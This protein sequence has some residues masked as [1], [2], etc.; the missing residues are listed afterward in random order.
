MG[1]HEPHPP[2]WATTFLGV[3]SRIFLE[4]FEQ[5]S[6]KKSLKILK[7][8]ITLLFYGLHKKFAKYM[9]LSKIS[10]PFTSHFIIYKHWLQCFQNVFWYFHSLD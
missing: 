3:Y 6:F 8:F 10:S 1:Y 2:L 9:S 4:Y 5:T 7:N